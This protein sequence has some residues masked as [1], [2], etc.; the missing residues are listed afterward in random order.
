MSVTQELISQLGALSYLGIFG[1]SL[2][3]N[4]VI[5]VPEEVVLLALGYLAGIG[6]V[7]AFILIPIVILGLLISDNV[8]YYLSKKGNKLINGV[9]NKFFSRRLESKREWLNLHIEKVIFFSRFL[10]QLRFL[11]PFLA[12]Q[13][14]VSWRKF[15]TY[16][17]AALVLYVPFL[18]WVGFYFRNRVEFIISGVN[19]IKN[20]VLIFIGV[21]LL[22]S[23]SKVARRFLFDRPSS[24][25]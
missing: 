8:I 22:I 18:I 17:L 9:Y 4:M 19:A 2:L 1:V 3:A 10:V 24:K 20:A 5:P 16:E 6:V 13:E 15:L 14:K 11:G 23:L 7:N 12:G 25:K 21:L